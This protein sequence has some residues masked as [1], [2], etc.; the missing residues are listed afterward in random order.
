[1]RRSTAGWRG[2]LAR[3]NGADTLPGPWLRN[4]LTTAE[5]R[6]MMSSNGQTRADP[7][8]AHRVHRR[9]PPP[10]GYLHHPYLRRRLHHLP[11]LGEPGPGPRPRLQPRRAYAG[12]DRAAVRP[13]AGRHAAVRIAGPPRL[14]SGRCRQ[15]RGEWPAHLP[16]RTPRPGCAPRGPGGVGLR[17]GPASDPGGCRWDG[18]ELV[19]G[20]VPAADRAAA[21]ASGRGGL[22]ARL[23]IALRP[24]G[25]RPAVAGLAG[26]ARPGARAGSA[27][28][29]LARP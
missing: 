6:T 15:R 19:P 4:G 1:M 7:L 14:G 2:T 11:I 13:A 8:G 25:R 24:S 16:A 5:G 27:P 10:G 29:R 20:P 22:P 3:A 23:R 17:R 28:Y 18:V 9:H 21:A 12:H 26:F